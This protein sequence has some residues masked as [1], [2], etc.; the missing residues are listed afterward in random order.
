MNDV[1]IANQ[2]IGKYILWNNGLRLFVI[3]PNPDSPNEF[4]VK[5]AMNSKTFPTVAKNIAEATVITEVE[6][7]K[8]YAIIKHN[9]SHVPLCSCCEWKNGKTNV[10]I[11]MNL[12]E[13]QLPTDESQRIEKELDIFFAAQGVIVKA[14]STKTGIELEFTALNTVEK[15][16]CDS[17]ID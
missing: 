3:G 17:T 5:Y 9:T 14:F 2:R 11:K 7:L 6:A 12:S 15:T 1:E 16:C 4:I 10:S 13:G 8:D